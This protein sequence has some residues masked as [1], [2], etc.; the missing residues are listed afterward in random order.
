MVTLAVTVDDR[1]VKAMLT[2][3]SA[4]MN[5]LMPVMRKI[6]DTLKNDALDNFKGQ[7]APDGTPWKPLSLATRI[8]RAKRLSGGSLLTKSGKRTKAKAY[9]V[10]TTAKALMDTGILRASINVLDATP[11]SVTV[12][13]RLKY[14]AIHQFGGMAGRGRKVR[15]PARPFI[16]MSAGAHRAIIDTINGYMG[17]NQ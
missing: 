10:M 15:I 1:E 4:R 6:G 7:H 13:S 11:T 12:G 14:A 16:G 8:A 5:N 3:L 9:A 2:R 17:I